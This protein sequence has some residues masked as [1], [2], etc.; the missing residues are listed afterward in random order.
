MH[1]SNIVSG[2]VLAFVTRLSNDT[3]ASQRLREI[4]GRKVFQKGVRHDDIQVVQPNHPTYLAGA[5]C[6]Q[7]EAFG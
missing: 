4:D 6:I 3:T 1:S 2:R 7:G 5:N